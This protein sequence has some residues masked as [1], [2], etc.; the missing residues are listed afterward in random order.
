[1][2]RTIFTLLVLLTITWRATAQAECLPA[3]T[4]EPLDTWQTVSGNYPDGGWIIYEVTMFLGVDYVFKTGCGDGATADHNTVIEWMTP[5]CDV[6]MSDD[7]GCEEDRSELSFNSFFSDGT[8]LLIGVR[9]SQGQAGS[10][11]MAYRSIG[12]VPGTCNDCPSYDDQLAPS[13]LWQTLTAGY[14]TDG[15]KV[16][17]VFT[18]PGMEYSFKTGCGDGATADHDTQLE[19]QGAG[20]VGLSLDDDGCE[21]GRSQVTWTA[22]GGGA[23]YVK[24]VSADGTAGTFTLAYRRSGG[25]GSLCAGCPAHDYPITPGASW[26]T[27]TSSYLSDGC[28]IYRAAVTEGYQYT[29]KTGCGNGAGADHDTH[30]QLFDA[31]CSLLVTDDNGCE[32]GSSI[33]EHVAG[34]TGFLYLKVSGADGAEGFYTL[35]YRKSGTCPTCPSYNTEVSP[36]MEWQTD[37]GSYY[38]DGCWMYKVNV[39]DGHTYVFETAEGHGGAA[40]HSTVLQILNDDCQPVV[41]PPWIWSE[42]QDRLFH[43]APVSGVIHVKVSGWMGAFGAHMMAYRDVG[44]SFDACDDVAPMT[45]G[46]NSSVVLAGSLQDATSDGDFVPSSPWNGLPVEWYAFDLQESC[47]SLIVSYC[48]QDPAWANTLNILAMSCP[49]DEV[50]TGTAPFQLCTD[51]NA[52]CFFDAITPGLYY[53]PLLYDAVNSIDGDYVISVTCSSIIVDGIEEGPGCGWS[54]YPNPGRDELWLNGPLGRRPAA[55]VRIHDLVGRPVWN[56]SIP[57]SPARIDT[58]S[59]PQGVYSVQ[60]HDGTSVSSFKWIKE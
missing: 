33:I 54:V 9:G 56:G 51:G 37:T 8:V 58:G 26:S 41:S 43:L 52:S 20:C 12:G 32:S 6:I 44:P 55:F 14:G 15:C 29:F 10:F 24:V 17:R 28:Q 53:L 18:M 38:N 22:T 7:G 35:A 11:T 30:L 50:L 47:Y 45:L 59:L 16:F 31:D 60:V 36:T 42:Q 19:I 5:V 25:N 40:D 2:S 34:S 13:S 4:I 46:W 1:M 23:I 39:T 57:S 49:G 48:G 21:S 27:S 3:D